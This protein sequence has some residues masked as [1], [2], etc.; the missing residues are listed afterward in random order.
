MNPLKQVE[1]ALE[2]E[3]DRAEAAFRTNFQQH[4]RNL[5]DNYASAKTE[6]AKHNAFLAVH[7]LILRGYQ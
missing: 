7:N 5:L 3:F 4:L 2:K 1:E 6:D